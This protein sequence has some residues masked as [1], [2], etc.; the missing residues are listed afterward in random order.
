MCCKVKYRCIAITCIWTHT[1]TEFYFTV[2]GAK[3]PSKTMP[4]FIHLYKTCTVQMYERWYSYNIK[5]CQIRI[6]KVQYSVKCRLHVTQ[7]F[8]L[9]LT[10]IVQVLRNWLNINLSLKSCVSR[11]G[12]RF[13]R[14]VRCLVFLGHKE[15]LDL[16]QV[17][18]LCFR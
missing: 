1:N 2:H 11:W 13:L 5:P 15:F 10:T 18:V 3:N 8:P 4:Y 6:L 17:F 12:S 7:L 14:H 9:T 16:F